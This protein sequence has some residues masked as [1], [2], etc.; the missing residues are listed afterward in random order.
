M[1]KKLSVIGGVILAV[2]LVCI[3]LVPRLIL[4]GVTQEKVAEDCN[5]SEV[6]FN[7][8]DEVRAHFLEK[9]ASL[10]AAGIATESESYAIDEAD[11][12]Y[13]DTV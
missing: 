11:G 7:E 12:L 3:L 4:L 2:L 1:K 10:N 13:I 6:F 8:Y 5:Y 9:V